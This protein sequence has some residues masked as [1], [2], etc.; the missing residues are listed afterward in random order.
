MEYG[1]MSENI[2]SVEENAQFSKSL[3]WKFQ[4]DYFIGKGVNAWAQGD[5][6]FYIT[7]NAFIAY[8]Y[9]QTALRYL[10]DGLKAGTINPDHPIYMM[11]I[12]TG[13][14][15]FSFLFLKH[16]YDFLHQF[17]LNHLKF[18][19]IMSDFTE[20]NV[21]YWQQHPQFQK[22]LNAGMLDFA[23]FATGEST[24]IHLIKQ[25]ITLGEN[26]CV[27]PLIAVGNYLFDTIPSDLFRVSAG[28]LEEGLISLKTP[29]E[30]LVNENTVHAPERVQVDFSYREINLPYYN[31]P[32]FDAVLSDYTHHLGDG[33]FLAP[34]SAIACIDALRKISNN[35]LLI[36][37]GDKAYSSMESMANLGAPHIAF[38]GSFS[39]MVNFDFISR[40]FK[41][42]G[43]DSLMPEDHEGFKICLFSLGQ[44]FS[45]LPET[46]WAY[47][48]FTRHMS[49][50]EFLEIKNFLIKDISQLD[51]DS[52]LALLK[53][54]YWDTDIF[55]SVVSQLANI[56]NQ[57]S[58]SYLRTLR[59]GLKYIEENYYFIRSYKN[60][61]FELGHI[62]HLLGDLEEA[63]L[64]YQ[65][66]LDF[67]G[68]ESPIHFNIGLCYYYKQDLPTALGHFKKAVE[69]NPDNAS[70][71]EWIAYVE[72]ELA[73]KAV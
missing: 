1:N 44:K 55:Y 48:H 8:G 19:Y 21:G 46:S 58:P 2:V 5:V 56:I 66:S 35:R 51:L 7:S 4:R 38:H 72:K 23:I 10:Q 53:F 25:N 47:E 69:F 12:G 32:A 43:G 3:L 9:A 39:L 20:S 60:V 34:T 45:E 26:S 41:N 61:P 71:K 28:K 62:Y 27:N 49:T 17:K 36:I 14:G 65:Q 16:M 33:N 13:S 57:A 11:E 67:F 50:K 24:S 37:G 40:Y 31:N 22:F 30:N 15:K 73:S 63:L 6:P 59:Q 54:S 70:A 64:H 68:A 42:I 18:C 29:K 52:L